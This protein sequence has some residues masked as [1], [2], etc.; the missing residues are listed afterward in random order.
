VDIRERHT[1]VDVANEH[2]AVIISRLKRANLGGIRLKA[3]L[4]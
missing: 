4:A 1:F 2:V 3:K